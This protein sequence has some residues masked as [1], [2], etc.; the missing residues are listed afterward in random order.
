[1]HWYIGCSGFYYKE[2]KDI[3]Y[4]K[5]LPQRAWFEF[6]AQHFNALEL[7]NT[8]YRFPEMAFLENWYSKAPTDFQFAVKVPRD[9]THAK[10]FEE[11]EALLSEFY[12]VL[13]AGL[14]EKLG[15]VLFQLP[16]SFDY[17]AARLKTITTQLDTTFIN[18]IEFRNISWWR[19]DVIEALRRKGITFCGVSYPGLIDSVVVNTPYPYYRFHGVPKLYNT[20]YEYGFLKNVVAAMG[21]VK[22][23]KAAYLFFNNTMSGAA[24]EN[25]KTAQQ[26]QNELS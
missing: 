15:L 19:D 11:T 24:I 7:N 13:K 21:T 1:M 4:P 18:V 5:G 20:P 25:A 6:Y 12:A 10:K 9:I 8:F 14:R 22:E 2:W 17:S 16:P 23:V 26:L 3:F